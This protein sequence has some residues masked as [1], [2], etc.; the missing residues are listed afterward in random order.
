MTMNDNSLNTTTKPKRYI[1][2]E[3]RDKLG[4][5]S[6]R[7]MINPEYVRWSLALEDCIMITEPLKTVD[8]FDYK[9]KN[10]IYHM[11]FAWWE[12]E[13]RP[14]LG[15]KSNGMYTKDEIDELKYN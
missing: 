14:H 4:R 1:K 3:M 12:D 7:N 10:K 8:W 9:Y 2:R 6:H 11:K 15:L 13:Y 5:I